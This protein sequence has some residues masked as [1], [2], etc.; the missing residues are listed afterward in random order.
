MTGRTV[1]FIDATVIRPAAKRPRDSLQTI[2]NSG[3]SEFKLA[4]RGEKARPYRYL[5]AHSES[6]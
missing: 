4:T 5:A 1:R 2:E 3:R 6:T